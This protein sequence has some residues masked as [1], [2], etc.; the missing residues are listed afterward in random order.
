MKT[1]TISCG[2]Y[3]NTAKE[4]FEKWKRV[5]PQCEVLAVRYRR[6]KE[7][8]EDFDTGCTYRLETFYIDFDYEGEQTPAPKLSWWKAFLMCSHHWQEREHLYG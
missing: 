8:Y 4:H 2:I 1:K 5:N 6:V 3:E 7:N